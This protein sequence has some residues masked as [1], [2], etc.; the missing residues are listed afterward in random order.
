MAYN[1]SKLIGKIIEVFGSQ[2]NFAKEMGLSE[3]TISKKLNNRVPF[4]QPEITKAIKLLHLNEED[5]QVY[6]FTKNVQ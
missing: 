3:R 6:F 2:A 4:K 5:V 1:Y